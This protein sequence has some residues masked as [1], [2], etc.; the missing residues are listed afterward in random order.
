MASLT[1]HIQTI[2]SSTHPIFVCVLSILLFNHGSFELFTRSVRILNGIASHEI[3]EFDG[4]LGG[5]AGLLHDGKVEDLVGLAVYFD[6]QAV[7]D[8]RRVN[9]Y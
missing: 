2:I 8:V 1:Q 6:S 9:G 7:F 5:T 3:L 4:G